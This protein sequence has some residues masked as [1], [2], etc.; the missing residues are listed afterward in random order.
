MASGGPTLN[1]R[2]QFIRVWLHLLANGVEGSCECRLGSVER[3]YRWCVSVANPLRDAAGHVVRWYGAIVDIEDRK[4][5]EDAL[6]LNEA[7]LTDAQ[8]LSHTGSFA[9]NPRNR[10]ALL[11]QGNVPAL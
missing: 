7:Y 4:R 8:R 11:V 2:N 10:L 6:R 5:A 3:G 1:D 9:L